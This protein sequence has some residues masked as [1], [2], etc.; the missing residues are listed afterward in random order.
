MA[1]FFVLDPGKHPNATAFWNHPSGDVYVN[2]GDAPFR[3]TICLCKTH[4][5]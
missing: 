2:Q 5:M 3:P 4:P 1:K